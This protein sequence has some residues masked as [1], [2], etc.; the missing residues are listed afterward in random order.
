MYQKKTIEEKQAQLQEIQAQGVATIV[1]QYYGQSPNDYSLNY[2]Q[3]YSSKMSPEERLELLES[4]LQTCMD[5]TTGVDHYL[6]QQETQSLKQE[7]RK[8]PQQTIEAELT[9]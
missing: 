6:M 8:Q 3:A 7:Q 2:L 1:L 9:L 4:T 5:I